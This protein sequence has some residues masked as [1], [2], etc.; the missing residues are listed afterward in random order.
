LENFGFLFLKV[1]FG[2]IFLWILR[3]TVMMVKK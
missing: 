2:I 3:K 1:K